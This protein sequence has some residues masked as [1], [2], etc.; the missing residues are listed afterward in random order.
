MA[1]TATTTKAKKT[2]AKAPAKTVAAKVETK[3]AVT[4]RDSFFSRVITPQV[5]VAEAVGTFM[6]AGAAMVAA[7]DQPLLVG[8]TMALIAAA[9]SGVSGAHVNPA[10]TFGLWSM[11][12]LEAVKVPFYWVA[13]F[14]GA[15]AAFLVVGVYSGNTKLDL[16]SFTTWNWNIVLLEVVGTAIFL[17][18][19]AAALKYAQTVLARAAVIGLSLTVGLVVAGGLVTTAATRA[20]TE[21]QSG[22]ITSVDASFAAQ[23]AALNPAV[24]LVQTERDVA[25]INKQIKGEQ[26]SQ[27][28]A[29]KQSHFTLSTILGTLVGAAIGGNLFAIITND[30]RRRK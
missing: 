20:Q 21:V 13:Q 4:S 28:D 2:T 16:G 29:T 5:L 15:L 23:G 18:G 27:A 12:K 7:P 9:I 17:F 1:K 3:K 10:V 19:I 24:A 14:I 6:L 22:K 8:L 30:V 25:A 11:R 26:V